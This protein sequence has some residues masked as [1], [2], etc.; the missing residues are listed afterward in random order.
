MAGLSRL[1][2]I[3]QGALQS[4][5]TRMAT[6]QNNIANASTPGYRRQ[7]VDMVTLGGHFGEVGLRGVHTRGPDSIRSEFLMGQIHKGQG[8]F[9]FHATRSSFAA[10]VERAMM[11]S[12]GQHLGTNVEAF[13]DSLRQAST[14]PGGEI[15]GRSFLQEADLLAG[16]FRET[17]ASL[18]RE[19][20]AM[21]GEA[22]GLVDSVNQ[23]LQEIAD[24]DRQIKQATQLSQPAGELMDQRDRLIQD[25]SEH[26]S[27]TVVSG[28]QG[29]VDL[30]TP[31]GRALVEGGQAR[32]VGIDSGRLPDQLHFTLT[33]ANDN[34]QPLGAPGGTLG[35]L[36]ATYNDTLATEV[37][38]LDALAFAFAT[39][40]NARHEAGF[41]RDGNPGEALFELSG[42]AQG[43]ASSLHLRQEI[44]DDPALL[45]FAG[46]PGEAPG[47]SSN[48]Q[49]LLALHDEPLVNGATFQE[50][51]QAGL[52]EVARTVSS[53]RQSAE[54]ASASLAQLQ[55]MEAS[56]TGVSLEE[57]MIALSES[58]R[59]F[60]AAL[61][62]M[63]A[64]DQMFSSLLSLKG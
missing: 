9:G 36:A 63:Q 52:N 26:L 17:A 15:E 18:Q 1:F 48:L 40:F 25:V 7:R 46:D 23:N 22:Q 4:H 30:I 38:R 8:D 61:K 47:G 45:A 37:E 5:Q 39:E 27:V 64:S 51:W 54:A 20:V 12:A 14:N 41:D 11:P 49:D 2:H 34:A 13:F 31:Q 28:D 29:S 24:L 57:E 56:I 35:G 33:G 19:R 44:S 6:L 32:T 58:Q 59:G 53:A 42:T 62:V 43:A 16:R 21:E 50:S 55:E 10:G 3:G 60:E